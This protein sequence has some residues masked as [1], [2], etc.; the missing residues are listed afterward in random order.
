MEGGGATMSLEPSI[1][2]GYILSWN[3]GKTIVQVP[4]D[5]SINLDTRWRHLHLFGNCSSAFPNLP[6]VFVDEDDEI[7]FLNFP[8]VSVDYDD[9]IT[10]K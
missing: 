9:K 6:T 10:T 4:L 2:G 7:R 5:R 8:T 3:Q 1:K